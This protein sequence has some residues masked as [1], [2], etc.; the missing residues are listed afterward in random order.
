M[1]KRKITETQHDILKL[2]Q[3]YKTEKNT[4]RKVLL[5]RGRS[6]SPVMQMSLVRLK[7]EVAKLD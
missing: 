6:R 5:Q 3:Q 4:L 1:N 2:I 7:E